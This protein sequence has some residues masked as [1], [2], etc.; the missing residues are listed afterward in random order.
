MMNGASPRALASR[1]LGRVARRATAV[2]DKTFER[3]DEGLPEALR[4]RLPTLEVKLG[5]H[6]WTV[7]GRVD[8]VE[9]PSAPPPVAPTPAATFWSSLPRG[10][11]RGDGEP[12]P[13]SRDDL[14]RQTED[15]RALIQCMRDTLE[16]LDDVGDFDTVGAVD[17]DMYQL[18]REL[19]RKMQLHRQSEAKHQLKDMFR[20]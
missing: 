2:V 19:E 17:D 3:V 20:I 15:V 12:G 10:V 7:H 6:T 9:A 8:P 1:L 13:I 16:H 5:E 4:R 14:P 18:W 11:R